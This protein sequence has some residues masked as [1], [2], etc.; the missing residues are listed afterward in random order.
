MEQIA[1]DYYREFHCIASA[2]RHTCCVGWEVDIDEETYQK[3]Q[4]KPHILQMIDPT[5]TPHFRLTKDERC[6]FLNREN[7]CKL[8]C[9]CGEDVLC[10]ICRDHPRFRNFFTDRIEIGLGLVCEEAARIILSQPDPMRLI[11]LSDDG[12]NVP[13]PEEERLLQNLREKLISE[14]GETGP[15]ARLYEYL[16][17]RHLPDALYDGRLCARIA[18]IE[19]A[20]QTITEEWERTDGTLDALVECARIWSYNVE[21][22]EEELE[23]QIRAAE[24]SLPR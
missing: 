24:D 22:D 12:K 4:Q 2:C 3:Y 13:M 21:Y 6:P 10:Q 7:L 15:R 23:K 11:T 18:F 20:F 9:A 16:V 19:N 5:E 8:I 17:Y 1:P 14:S